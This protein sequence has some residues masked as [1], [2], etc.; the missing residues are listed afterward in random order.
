MSKCQVK[1][2]TKDHNFEYHYGWR[3]V[4]NDV[5]ENMIILILQKY[6]PNSDPQYYLGI[7]GIFGELVEW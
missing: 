4:N 2:I 7:N 3:L 5:L 6:R 1:N